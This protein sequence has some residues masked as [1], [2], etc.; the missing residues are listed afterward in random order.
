MNNICD[1]GAVND[2]NADSTKY[3]Q[4][5]VDDCHEKGGGIVYVPYGTYKIA[6]VRLY[7]DIHFLFEPGAKFLGSEDPDAYSERE[8]VPYPLYQDTSHSYF[9]HSMFWA[10]E[11]NNISFTGL[12]TIDMQNVWEKEDY[13]E[14]NNPWS[15]RRAAKI[16]ALKNCKNITIT[17]LT[18][19]RAT[20]LA[21][22]LAGCEKV[23]L[24]KLTIDVDMD[25]ISPDCCKDVIISDC[26]VRTGDDAIVIKS[27]YTLNRIKDCEN[28]AVTNCSI[29]TSG[30]A[31]KI[32][33]ESNGSF[34][35]ISVSNCVVYDTQFAGVSLLV[36]DGGHLDGVC[37]TNLTMTNVGYPFLIIL[38]NR[39]R[40]PEGTEMGSVRN[41]MISNITCSGPYKKFWLPQMTSLWEG[42]RFDMP[43]IMPSSVTGQPDRKVENITFSNIHLGVP[44][45]GTLE[46]KNMVVPEITKMYPKNPAFGKT[47]PASGIYFRH[48]KNLTLSNVIVETIEKDERNEFVFDDVTN[49]KL[50]N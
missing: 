10:E 9:H 8:H 38:S 37:V 5:A 28:I 31:V 2:K 11:C 6:T 47:L 18:L 24:S 29:T 22:Y 26:F 20:D 21:V 15:A 40:G 30:S 23:L 44:G 46:D 19:L 34:R 45:G 14:E 50:L 49:L 4:L 42:E 7:S 32:G 1:F 13:P 33:T 39:A 25:G 3:V 43:W 12:G 36:T 27:T 17:D 41:I 48:V 16:F 35:N